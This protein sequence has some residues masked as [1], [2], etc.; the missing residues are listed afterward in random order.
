MR[1]VQFHAVEAGLPRSRCSR[2]KQPRQHGRQFAYVCVLHVAHALALAHAQ[3]LE[4]ARR[5][6]VCEFRIAH[7][8]EPHPQRSLIL[9]CAAQLFAQGIVD[10]E[11]PREEHLALG[12]APDA[13]EIDQLDQQQRLAAAGLPHG[14]DHAAQARHEAVMPDAQQRP[15]GDIT[16]PGGLDH[17]RA[18]APLGEARVP[19]D[20][21]V[22][23]LALLGGAPGDHRRNPAA[24]REAAAAQIERAEEARAGGF[25]RCGPGAGA[26]CVADS[27]GGFP[28]G[29]CLPE[30]MKGNYF[31]FETNARQSRFDAR[32][33]VR[34]G[35][36]G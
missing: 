35:R 18:R 32:A 4:F 10:A 27:L 6:H 22:C 3:A 21:I 30:Y 24:L 17:D 26:G 14:L 8:R 9:L 28:H 16:D 23:D 20:H 31:R 13:Q 34:R 1:V 7:R 33:L 15:A 29:A 12:A 36:I 5:K 11:V 2:S 25:F 19:L